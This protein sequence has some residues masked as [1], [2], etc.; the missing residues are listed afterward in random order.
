MLA[1]FLRLVTIGYRRLIGEREDV[2]HDHIIWIDLGGAV[3]NNTGILSHLEDH[4]LRVGLRCIGKQDNKRQKGDNVAM[5]ILFGH[6]I[7]YFSSIV[8]DRRP[9]SV[10]EH[11]IL[12]GNRQLDLKLS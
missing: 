6:S 1:E 8:I 4:A 3:S 2:I 9:I 10:A 11:L 12:L 7:P 5:L